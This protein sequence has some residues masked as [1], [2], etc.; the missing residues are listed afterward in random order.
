LRNSPKKQVKNLLSGSGCVIFVNKIH[1][2][3][4]I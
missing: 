4:S 2:I 3:Y 1:T